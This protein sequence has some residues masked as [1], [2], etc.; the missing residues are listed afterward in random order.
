M[1]TRSHSLLAT[2]ILLAL[3]PLRIVAQ[4]H[5][6]ECSDTEAWVPV[7]QGIPESTYRSAV[8]NGELYVVSRSDDSTYGLRAWNG[9]RWRTVSTFRAV[10][11]YRANEDFCAL[12][13]YQGDLYL[14]GG[15][16]RLNNIPG[17][18]GLARWNGSSWE[19]VPGNRMANSSS[20]LSSTYLSS[21]FPMTVY[22]GELF[23]A[24]IFFVIDSN[25]I[26]AG[27][28]AFNGSTWRAIVDHS[29]TD[30]YK[31][32]I[33]I[34]SFAEWRGDLYVGGYFSRIGGTNAH[35][36]ARW[37]GTT[38]STL[39]TRDMRAIAGL[40]V[41][42][43]RLYAIRNELGR[44]GAPAADQHL[45]W[46]DGISWHDISGRPLLDPL[47]DFY[48]HVSLAPIGGSEYFTAQQLGP[49]T[50]LFRVD[51][52]G[53][54]RVAHPGG[55][56]RFLAAYN[57][58]LYCGGDFS[59]ACSIQT[60]NVAR[61]CTS[62]NCAGITGRVMPGGRNDCGNDSAK[63]GVPLRI[64]ELEPGARYA[65]TGA[66]GFYRHFAEPGAYMLGLAPKR[67]WIQNCPDVPPT[68]AITVNA[69]QDALGGNNFAVTP[70]PGV[71]DLGVSIAAGRP[72]PGEGIE[73]TISCTNM[74]T[75]TSHGVVS[76]RFDP[77]LTLE[78][79]SVT[80]SSSTP[81][82][83]DWR[84]DDMAPDE[85]RT[86]L[87]WMAVPTTATRGA[88]LCADAQIVCDGDAYPEDNASRTCSQIRASY[89]PN[90]IAV[91]PAGTGD[92]GQLAPTDSVL[93]YTVHF[94]NTGNDTARSIIVVDDVS[95]NLDL[96]SL[97]LGASSHP[98]SLSM[99]GARS[100]VWR[101]DG[102]N[103]PDSAHTGSASEGYL[104][105]AVRLNRGIAPNTQIQNYAT[106]YF[107]YNHPLVTNTVI[108]TVPAP[109]GVEPDAAVSTGVALYPNP[110]R[111]V[112]HIRGPLAPQSRVN[113]RDLMGRSVRE[114]RY[115]GSGEVMLD[116]SGLAGG[117][118]IVLMQTPYGMHAERVVL[119]R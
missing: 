63:T 82:E 57:G 34:T 80:P 10:S 31:D 78:S 11:G 46:W 72:R 98:Y 44:V 51:T 24:G 113:V 47:G 90:D 67:H 118:Y 13:A 91:Q 37:D 73:Y 7:D 53:I 85:V 116:L 62:F 87:V 100:L 5:P 14:T 29:S 106:I 12:Q 64:I 45:T 99:I 36:L 33:M 112:V 103:L 58:D 25:D 3:L 39:G 30:F 61:L 56:T 84:I 81:M 77:M 42:D 109:S 49:P 21:I 74:G 6:D 4:P 88:L 8:M 17:T 9:V 48:L 40:F 76:L 119:E 96:A 65:I 79:S 97:V 117:V 2:L 66:D 20:F 95:S 102:I 83:Y 94:Q 89:D 104:S 54:H 108:S 101:F 32:S 111:G 92:I 107:D 52:G 23:V 93:T 22:K 50:I 16:S 15:F 1:T 35:G 18:N 27:I 70:V 60:K 115:D 110:T 86:I 105:F 69:P 28:V 55:L 43:D 19:A 71:Q 68:Y 75:V 114:Y 38:W 41:L 26:H 59:T